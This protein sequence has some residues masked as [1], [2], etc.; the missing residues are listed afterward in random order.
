MPV[1]GYLELTAGLL[2][3]RPGAYSYTS[4]P[5]LHRPTMELAIQ[6]LAVYSSR[7]HSFIAIV[8]TVEHLN[9]HE[10]CNEESY[11]GRLWTRAE[12]LSHLLVNGAQSMW[13]ATAAQPAAC[14]PM[15]NDWLRGSALQIFDGVS[16][17]CQRKH[18]GMDQCDREL[19]VQPLLGLYSSC[20]SN[21]RRQPR[22]CVSHCPIS[23]PPL[24]PLNPSPDPDPDIGSRPPSPLKVW[25]PLCGGI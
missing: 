10:P 16:T 22:S 5:Q 25:R 17:C 13:V 4:V 11:K 12:C 15:E 14:S 18:V 20:G 6:S 2:V 9:T 24:L 7:A 3:G 1:S 19:L 21:E 8:P 23:P